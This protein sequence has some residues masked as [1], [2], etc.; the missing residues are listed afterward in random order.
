MAAKAGVIGGGCFCITTR[1]HTD[2]QVLNYSDELQR[3]WRNVDE[4][5]T[6]V[7]RQSIGWD[8]DIQRRNSNCRESV[9]G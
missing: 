1:G 5:R 8:N 7:H 3:Q 4:S 2:L 6:F 9:S